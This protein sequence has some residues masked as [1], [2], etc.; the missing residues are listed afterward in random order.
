MTGWRLG[1]AAGPEAI[2]SQMAK[3]Q[4]YTF[5]CA[6]SP[7]QEAGLAALDVPMTEAIGQYRAKRDL[8]HGLL[9]RKFQTVR[10]EGAFYIFPRA[11]EGR[12]ASE[13]VAEAIARN[14][15]IIPGNVFSER[16]THFR[17]SFAAADERLRRGCEVLC[18]M[19]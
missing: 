15:L 3:L 1:Y 14:V 9:S 8:V 2:L 4:Q 16:D 13:F 18:G 12:S 11:P 19:V 7:F 6:P 10:P 5:V 17:I